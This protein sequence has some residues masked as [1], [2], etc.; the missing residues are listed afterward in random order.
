MKMNAVLDLLKN[1]LQNARVQNL[2]GAPSSPVVGQIYVDTTGGAGNE[3][4][5]MYIA[6]TWWVEIAF[7]ARVLTKRLDQFA[8]PT[9]PVAMNSQRLTGLLDPTSA[10]DAAT[11]AYVDALVNGTDWKASV[12]VATAVAGTLATSF[13]NGQVVDGITL[14]TGNRI[15]IKDQ[16]TGAENGIY[17]VN[18]SGAPTRAVDADGAGEVTAN[19]ACFV[20]EGT[21]NADTQWR[22]TTNNPITI[23][24]TALVFAQIGASTSY[25]NGTGIS[26][27]TNIFS[28]DVAT[29]SR[30]YS[31]TFGDWTSTTFNIDHNLNSVR[32]VIVG[33]IKESNG[34][35]YVFDWTYSTANRIIVTAPIAPASNEFRVNVNAIT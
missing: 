14:V 13:A 32:K 10:Q 20:E 19:M 31:A 22:L 2:T 1:E 16:A 27:S 6:T 23:G 11:R 8:A 29:V 35:P 9:G 34:E 5:Y 30:A 21:A 15:L 3:I 18:A 7:M 26:L 12:R 24:S 28:I 4:F 25:T 33:F 17:T